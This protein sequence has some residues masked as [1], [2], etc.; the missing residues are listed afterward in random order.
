MVAKEQLGSVWSAVITIVIEVDRPI[1]RLLWPRLGQVPLRRELYDVA[2]KTKAVRD[3][4]PRRVTARI[5][6]LDY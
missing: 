6:R 1:I 4:W 5:A 2:V 3:V